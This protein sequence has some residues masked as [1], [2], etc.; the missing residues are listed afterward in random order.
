M[1]TKTIVMSAA[2]V[3]A[4]T[5]CSTVN[6][7][8]MLELISGSFST[9][10]TGSSSVGDVTY[11]G[12]I[13]QWNVEFASGENVLGGPTLPEIDLGSQE[14]AAKGSFTPPLANLEI[15]YTSGGNFGSGPVLGT[16]GG[17]T[18]TSVTDYQ[19]LGS[20]PFSSSVLLTTLGTYAAKPG[21]T[22]A[23]SGSTVGNT[24]SVAGPYWLSEE[25]VITGSQSSTGQATSFDANSQ[26]VPDGAP[27][28]VLLG[29]M[30]ACFGLV[31]SRFDG[32]RA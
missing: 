3:S 8:P 18:T 4:L 9:L 28:M 21:K 16:V 10:I 29:S 26:V 19:Y 5:L 14:T 32:K 13:G 17:T 1:K 20:S 15:W 24:G 25:V 23:F 2:L 7:N 31:R 6:A 22:L 30:F 27:T 11:T 12:T